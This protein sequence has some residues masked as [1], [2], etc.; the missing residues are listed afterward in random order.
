MWYQQQALLRVTFLIVFP[1][2]HLDALR[3]ETE[4]RHFLH[5]ANIKNIVLRLLYVC[6][7]HF[8]QDELGSLI[9]THSITIF[10]WRTIRGTIL[11]NVIRLTE[12]T[13]FVFGSIYCWN[14]IQTECFW[15]I[16]PIKTK[17]KRE[18]WIHKTS[19]WRFKVQAQKAIIAV[20]CFQTKL[21]AFSRR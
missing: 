21:I 12:Y 17:E 8:K 2:N 3:Y 13:I 11:H 18:I 7:I 14:L 9:L 1:L 16:M 5:R 20:F 15:K 4:T 19:K 6:K 10:H